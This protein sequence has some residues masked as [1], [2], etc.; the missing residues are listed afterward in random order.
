[1]SKK[2]KDEGHSMP[3]LSVRIPKSLM[4]K[5][6]KRF[7]KGERSE[8]VRGVLEIACKGL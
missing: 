1:M 8:W 5:I 3:L 4:A 6:R 2:K 7:R